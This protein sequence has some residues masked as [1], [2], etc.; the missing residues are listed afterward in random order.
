MNEQRKAIRLVSLAA[1]IP[2]DGGGNGGKAGGAGAKAARSTGIVAQP[3]PD[4]A[5]PKCG[6]SIHFGTDVPLS[7]T[8]CQACGA[9]ILVPGQLDGFRLIERIGEGAMGEIFRARD[10]ALKRDVAIKVVHSA[11]A[12]DE[13]HA[14]RLRQEAQA[15]A[16]ISHPRVA[17]VHALGFCND[18]PYLVMEL[19]RGEDMDARLRREGAIDE[20][21]ALRVAS[22]VIEGLGVLHKRGLT[23]GDIKP[24]NI[25]LDEEGAAKLVDF[26]LSGMAR[27]DGAGAIHGTP[28]YIAPEL[29]RGAADSSQTDLY[30]LGATLYHLLS[31]KPPF[32]GKTP[33]EVVRARLNGPAEPLSRQAPHLSSLT[34]R[35]V[36]RLLASDPAQR[37]PDCAAVAADIRAARQL[38]ETRETP[39]N[40]TVGDE[41]RQEPSLRR[42]RVGYAVLSAV[43]LVEAVLLFRMFQAQS[44]A[45]RR[46]TAIGQAVG[47]AASAVAQDPP[48]G[49]PP[50]ETTPVPLVFNRRLEPNWFSVNLGESVRGSTV[51]RQDA[52]IILSDGVALMQD[53]DDCR[54]V[55]TGVTG[56]FA[57]S[58]EVG[59]IATTDPLA[60]TGLLVRLG[61][62]TDSPGVFFGVQGDGTLL[63]SRRAPGEAA[64]HIERSTS[65]IF[66]PCRLRLIRQ[67][68]RFGADVSSDGTEW[69]SVGECT[70]DLAPTVRVGLAVTSHLS[71]K[72]ATAEFRNLTLLVP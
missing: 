72:M 68:R 14:A 23:H 62:E 31:G 3:V 27:R 6:T 18:H 61:R 35:L 20:R 29:L 44:N 30:S 12:A 42:R 24:A 19:V 56:A 2:A 53:R 22:E 7:T 34:Q 70:L 51:W 54:Y 36:M 48:V 11:H 69:Q 58:A 37:Y 47:P 50:V 16:S 45:N 49:A 60:R 17:Q 4:G 39:S 63:L 8:S 32:A 59:A 13:V 38:L 26:G 9:I 21:T 28:H 57:F 46:T 65:S 25:V 5:C 43:A 1:R 41:G 66:L 15:A 10:E 55:H 52:L 64:E 40:R 33:S 67:G 71:G